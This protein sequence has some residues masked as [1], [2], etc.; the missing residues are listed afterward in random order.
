MGIGGEQITQDKIWGHPRRGCNLID[1]SKLPTNESAYYGYTPTAVDAKKKKTTTTS[2]TTGTTSSGTST[3]TYPTQWGE[4]SDLYSK[5]ASGTYTNTGIDYLTKLLG[6]GGTAGKLSSYA[7]AQKSKMMSDYSDAV[8]ELMESAGVGGTRYSSGLQ[9]AIANYGAKLSTDYEADLASKYLSALGTDTTTAQNLASTLLGGAATGAGGLESI[10]QNYAYL[11]MAVAS[12][13][14]SLGT[15][16]SGQDVSGWASILS[17]LMGN[18]AT[19]TAPTATSQIASILGGLDW[20]DI[21]G[22]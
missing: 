5:L 14:N 8:K 20:E 13:M 21:L 16:L 11:P 1:W 7:T 17:S 4:A 9:N 18:T 12:A 6:E 3:V 22:G 19:S 10:G 15:S 2:D